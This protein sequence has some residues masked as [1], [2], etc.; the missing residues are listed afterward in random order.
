MQADAH[1]GTH[2]GKTTYM[3]MMSVALHT[4]NAPP[5]LVVNFDEANPS[6]SLGQLDLEH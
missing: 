1:L 6:L 3:R 2:F 5:K 4:I